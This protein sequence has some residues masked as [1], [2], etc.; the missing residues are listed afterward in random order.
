MR[1]DKIKKS[2]QPFKTDYV[3]FWITDTDYIVKSAGMIRDFPLHTPFEEINDFIFEWLDEEYTIKDRGDYWEF[4]DENGETDEER[5]ERM[6]QE[7]MYDNTPDDVIIE[8]IKN[9]VDTKEKQTYGEF[10]L[11]IDGN[12]LDAVI[13][14]QDIDGNTKKF[15]T[16]EHYTNISDLLS[17][18]FDVVYSLA[19][20][21]YSYIMQVY[22]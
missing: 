21:I 12:V 9:L 7:D 22:C 5:I 10:E 1:I 2:T 16:L 14:L 11:T 18:E 19:E 17:G 3:S 13:T 4:V 20:A 6:S 15:Y 8:C